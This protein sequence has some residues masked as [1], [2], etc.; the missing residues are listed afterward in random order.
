[1]PLHEAPHRAAGGRLSVN[2][3]YGPANPLGDMAEAPPTHRLP[4]QPMAPATAHQ[5]VRDELMLDGNARLNLATFVTTWMEPE[6]G[7]LMAECRDKNMIDK[8][9]YPRTAELERRCVAMLADLWKAP[10]PATAVGCSTTGSSEACMLAGM[11]LKRRWAKRNADRYPGARPNLVMGVNVQV[12]W[13]K[14]CNFWEVEARLVPMEGERFHLDPQA[15]AELCDENTIGVVGILGSTFDGSYEP[16]ADL[17]AALDA[18]QERTGLDVPVHVDGASG[19]MVAPFLD[20]DL[21]WDFRLPRVASINTSGHKYGL[22]YPGVGWAL[23]RDAEALPE[24]LVFRVNY[25]GGDMPTFALNFSRP[26]AQVVAQY[27]TFLRLGRDGYRAVQQ[28]ARD[29]ATGLAGRV[30]ALGDFHL[31]TRG[32]ELPVFAFTTAPDVKAYDVFD[33]SRRLRESGWLVP[34][35][36]FP[37]NREDLSVLRVVCRNGFSADLAELLAQDLER[38]LPDLRRQPRPLTEDKGAATSFHH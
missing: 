24:E 32:D 4:D 37:P 20:E 5:L 3:F 10:D 15:A 25:L 28:A 14:F 13:E 21:V 9:E 19:A 12:C 34:A 1:M 26:G 11:A 35:Y 23:W 6:A 33:V 27:Y 31:L 29:V 18:V 17:C 16:I 30:E 36:T 38:L 7:V 22:V 8:D 2:P